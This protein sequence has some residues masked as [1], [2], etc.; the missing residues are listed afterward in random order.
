MK[1]QEAKKKQDK[2]K[3]NRLTKPVPP[4]NTKIVPNKTPSKSGKT[5]GGVRG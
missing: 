4:V 5:E 2:T 1:N 3:G